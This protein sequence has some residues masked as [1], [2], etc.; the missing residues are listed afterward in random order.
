MPTRLLGDSCS[1][2]QEAIP[3]IILA[4]D[5]RYEEEGRILS[6]GEVLRTQAEQ[7][8]KYAQ[9]R[10]T[11]G[12]IITN[13]NGFETLSSHQ[14]Q[15]FHNEMCSHAIDLNVLTA[16][17]KTYLQQERFYYPIVGLALVY[18]LKS[19]GDWKKPDLP[20]CHCPFS[21]A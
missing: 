5:G 21:K 19:G 14:A 17:R 8:E 1:I 3:E 2:L 18:G 4:Y 11:P 15:V 10:T 9:G 13:A 20:H 12:K 16:D 6:I 7:A